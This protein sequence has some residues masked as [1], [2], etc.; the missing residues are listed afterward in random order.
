MFTDRNNILTLPALGVRILVASFGTLVCTSALAQSAVTGI[1]VTDLDV[2]NYEIKVDL[3][4]PLD[5][6]PDSFMLKSPASI[7]IDFKDTKIAFENEHIVVNGSPLYDVRSVESNNRTRVVIGLNGQATHSVRVAGN[8]AY[9]N[10]IGSVEESDT[11]VSEIGATALDSTSDYTS[12]EQEFGSQ[13]TSSSNTGFSAVSGDGKRIINFDFRR[14]R[15]G[16]G[17]AMISF[18][19]KDAQI[20]VLE[21]GRYIYADFHNFDIP[22]DLIKI[23]DVRDFATPVSTIEFLRSSSGR[24]IRMVVTPIDSLYEQYAYQT[25]DTFT[26][27]LKPISAERL[28]QLQIERQGYSGEKISL[29]F[30]NIDVRTVL[31]RLADFTDNN[32]IVSDSVSGSVTM[33]L[34]NVPW[35]QAL[36]QIL[37][38]RGLAKVQENNVILVAPISE[39]AN[40]QRLELESQAQTRNLAP[41]RSEFFQVNYATASSIA[42]LISGENGLISDRGSI[43]VDERTNILI[44]QETAE[45]LESIRSIISRIDI[46]VRQV[47]IDSRIVVASDAFINEIGGRFG[48]SQ[49]DVTTSPSGKSASGIST[50]GTVGGLTSAHLNPFTQSTS[51]ED[52]DAETDINDLLNVSLPASA[53]A[54][55]IAVGLQGRSLLGIDSGLLALELSAMTSENRGEVVSSPRVITTNQQE[56][57]I[58]QGVEIPYQEASSS[59]ATTISFK[60]AV[61]SLKVTPQ[62]TPNDQILMDL[63]LKNDSVGQVFSGIP[64]IN[65]RE[66][67]TQVVVNNGETI[68][69]GGIYQQTRLNDIVKVPFFGDIPLMKVFF[70]RKRVSD[71]KNE[72]LLFVTPSIIRNQ[73]GG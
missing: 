24:S 54:G 40:R 39:I 68:V 38:S 70:R 8:A 12:S 19:G 45:K 31:T 22:N 28:T 11:N 3:D 10:V 44:I 21:E 26:L 1:S 41:V 14:N 65:T 42:E 32:I 30:Q 52:I 61:L 36:D 71:E 5:A 48:L 51:G 17:Q 2:G 15:L 66:V 4:R 55:T 23:F 69:L 50:A 60:Q 18:R 46:P 20:D 27:E 13:S 35:D 49:R 64:S 56:A 34:K 47:L 33:R 25:S 16:H 72:L 9:I 63:N 58:E 59:G 43:T 6:T 53:A 67:N 57:V 62:I 37:R 29:D 73:L 7:I